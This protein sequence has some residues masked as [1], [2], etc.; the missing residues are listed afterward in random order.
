M[1]ELLVAMAITSLI[2]LA[3]LSLIGQTTSSYTE[4]QRAVNTLSQARAF[5]QFFDRELTTRLPATP[6]IYEKGGSGGGPAASDKIAI[7]R[8]ISP[9]EQ[10]TVHPGDLNTSIYYVAVT[11]DLD[12]ARSPKLFRRTL[13]PTET[14]NL[15]ES[16][17]SPSF[18]LVDPT[19]DE[20]IINNILSFKALPKKREST[21]VIT[22]WTPGSSEPPA[23][24]D[25][26]I[27]FVDDSS[28]QRYRTPNEWSRLA[29]EPRDSELQII[30][31]YTRT[32]H[33]AR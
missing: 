18:P 16:G 15:I 19:Q 26:T 4:T 2:M 31:S 12:N 14:Q 32:F 28:A 21:G 5:V 9:A 23:A 20:P 22:D 11:P 24:I 7:I 30:R 33:I 1:I 27:R 3:L 17:S 8:A 6:L 29:T 25:L 10:S 13:N